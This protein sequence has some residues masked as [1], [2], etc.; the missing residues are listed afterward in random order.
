MKCEIISYLLE[1]PTPTTKPFSQSVPL[2]FIAEV[3]TR[4]FRVNL[5]VNVNDSLTNMQDVME[6]WV[7]A[8]VKH[9]LYF[10]HCSSCKHNIFSLLSGPQVTQKLKM[11]STFKVINL[12]VNG[13]SGRCVTSI[14]FTDGQLCENLLSDFCTLLLFH[15]NAE[16][17]KGYA[18]SDSACCVWKGSQLITAITLFCLICSFHGTNKHS[19]RPIRCIKMLLPDPASYRTCILSFQLKS[20][21]WPVLYLFLSIDISAASMFRQKTIK[22]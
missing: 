9:S 22:I 18:V 13:S 7:R 10:F 12:V 15:R 19:E 21:C 16:Q 11:N 1:T 6:T 2:C 20:V 5:T 17:P 14:W 8:W 3:K 4:F